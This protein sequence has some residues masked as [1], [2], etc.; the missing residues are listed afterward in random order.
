MAFKYLFGPIPSRRLGISLGVDLVPHKVCNLNCLYCES[1]KT[2]KHT[3]ERREYVLLKGIIDELNTYL[4]ENPNLDYITFSGAGEPTL[5]SSIGKII[6]FLKANYPTYKTALITNSLLF[7]S[8]ILR[9]EVENVDLI[10]PSLDAASQDVFQ[11]INRPVVNIKIENV[12]NGL[13]LFN[14]VFKGEMWLEFFVLQG[15]NDMENELIAVKKAIEKIKPDKIQINTLDRPGTQANLNT[16]SYTRL[17]EIKDFFKPFTVEI[18]SRQS[19]TKHIIKLK[20]DFHTSILDAITRRPCSE[21]D[22]SQILTISKEEALLLLNNMIEQG[23]IRRKIQNGLNFYLL[24]N[25]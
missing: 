25:S 12:I 20:Q 14:K 4:S 8:E 9:K 17:L 24:P 11:K 6:Q 2:N 21:E 23:A 1:G 10:L 22:I 18:V 7:E 16:A 3:N 5:N 13:A 15:I 19:E